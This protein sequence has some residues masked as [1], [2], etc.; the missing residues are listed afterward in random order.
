MPTNIW[1]TPQHV[2]REPQIGRGEL[3]L[4]L[5]ARQR[6]THDPIVGNGEQEACPLRRVFPWFPRQVLS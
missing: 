5:E 6:Q 4:G 1:S 3:W 2:Q